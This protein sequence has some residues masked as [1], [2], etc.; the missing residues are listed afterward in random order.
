MTIDEEIARAKERADKNSECWKHCIAAN[1]CE[2]CEKEHEQIAEW[3][4]ELKLLKE[5]KKEF[6]IIAR[7]NY[8]IGYEKAIDDVLNTI[9]KY[10]G[11][12]RYLVSENIRSEIEQLKEQNKI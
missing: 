1:Y 9:D 7:D 3:L 2:T 11:S 8:E 6:Q 5:E 4:E 10:C 12:Q